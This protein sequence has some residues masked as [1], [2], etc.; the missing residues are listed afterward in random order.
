[1][2]MQ[3]TIMFDTDDATN[4]VALEQLIGDI[5]PHMVDNVQITMTENNA[6]E[7]PEDEPARLQDLPR[8][9][10]VFARRYSR[11]VYGLHDGF[12]GGSEAVN[13]QNAEKSRY[14]ASE[15]TPPSDE[16]IVLMAFHMVA[17]S[18]K[19]AQIALG[20]MLPEVGHMFDDGEHKGKLEAYW[21]AMDERYDGSD[22]DTAVFVPGS[23]EAIGAKQ[24]TLRAMEPTINRVAYFKDVIDRDQERY[25]GFLRTTVVQMAVRG[26]TVE[27]IAHALNLPAYKVD[28]ILTKSGV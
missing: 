4:A 16:H 6:P 28:Q 11:P 20:C 2:T 8:P 21:T 24:R 17:P 18:M 22:C 12:I 7:E 19:D 15:V 10:N 23:G 9:R 26:L 5:A 25:D 3:I 13:R 1:M 14:E 27:D